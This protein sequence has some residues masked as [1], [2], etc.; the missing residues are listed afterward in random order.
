MDRK[1]KQHS[2]TRQI[3]IGRIN[4]RKLFVEIVVIYLFVC[5]GGCMI[6]DK[7]IF[8]PPR[9]GYS[10]GQDIVKIDVEKGQSISAI[11]LENPDAEFTI[12]YSHGNAEDIG[13]NQW[14]FQRFAQHGYS[15]LGYDYRGYGTSDGR[16][17]EKNAYKDIQAAYSWLTDERNIQPEK[18]IAYG[19]SVGGGLA[20]DL[21]M[22]NKVGAVVL[23]SPFVTAFRVVTKYPISP[24]DK[25]RN[26]AK[27]DKVNCPLLIIHGQDDTIVAPWHGKKLFDKANDP[28]LSLW[29]ENANHNDDTAGIAGDQYWQKLTQLAELAKNSSKQ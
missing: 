10:D 20:V 14:L 6:A 28:K 24:F 5:M 27:I 1:T 8:L 4:F 13:H 9:P 17:S 29:V 21:A 26:I 18:I 3:L 19:R 22:R 15:V 12:L 16:P 23:E 2:V 25:F 11:H 7:M